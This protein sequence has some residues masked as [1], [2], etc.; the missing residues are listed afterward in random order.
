MDSFHQPEYGLRS[1]FTGKAWAKKMARS[2]VG[3]SI[4][5]D[6]RLRRM[7]CRPPGS[8]GHARA[9]GHDPARPGRRSMVEAA[10]PPPTIRIPESN[11]A[12]PRERSGVCD[13]GTA[14][15]ALGFERV[16]ERRE[17]LVHVTHDPEVGHREDRRLLVLVDGDDV[18]GA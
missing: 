3:K 14:D 10:R 6:Q 8:D 18:L 13:P 5:C 17:H 16:D 7:Y 12:N 15:S 11:P 9:C 4:R 1:Q 2:V